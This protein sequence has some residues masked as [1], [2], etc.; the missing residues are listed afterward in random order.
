MFFS[1]HINFSPAPPHLPP[2]PRPPLLPPPLSPSTQPPQP[3]L[4]DWPP[5]GAACHRRRASAKAIN[6]TLD[7]EALDCNISS[8]SAPARQRFLLMMQT[9][10]ALPL[11]SCYQARS[12]DLYLAWCDCLWDPLSPSTPW[13]CRTRQP[14]TRPCRV[15]PPCPR[16]RSSHPPPFRTRWRCRASP[17]PPTLPL[18][19]WVLPPAQ[20]DHFALIFYVSVICALWLANCGM[21]WVFLKI[22]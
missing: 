14:R 20:F 15:W 3:L 12:G 8:S 10:S 22:N 13:F 9:G 17:G 18:G 21:L 19:G 7:P 2:P 5:A 16:R 11:C 6:L 1:P 4:V